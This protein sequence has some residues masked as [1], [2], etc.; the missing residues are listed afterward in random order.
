MNLLRN[1]G[2]V[3]L[4]GLPIGSPQARDDARVQLIN[5]AYLVM[6]GEDRVISTVALEKL[7]LLRLINFAITRRANRSDYLNSSCIYVFYERFVARNSGLCAAEC[8]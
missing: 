4:M 2:L 1:A 6:A 5:R 7:G 3:L 8:N